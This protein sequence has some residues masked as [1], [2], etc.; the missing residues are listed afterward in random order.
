MV[1]HI[2]F[3]KLKEVAAGN[4]KDHNALK[5]KEKLESLQGKIKGLLSIQVGINKNESS[6]AS[7]ICLISEH[8]TWDDLK[9]YQDHPLHKE[10]AQFI[11]EIRE[12]R[13]VIDFEF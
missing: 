13:S 3:W 11:G 7:D 10:V 8:Q 12:S 4:N 2:V 5:I 9:F 6:D 1:K